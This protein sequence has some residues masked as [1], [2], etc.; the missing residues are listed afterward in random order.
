[1]QEW[2]IA[3]DRKATMASNGTFWKAVLENW[4]GER[5]AA[6]RGGWDNESTGAEK[7]VVETAAGQRVREKQTFVKLE[8]EMTRLASEKVTTAH[9]GRGEGADRTAAW[10][11]TTCRVEFNENGRSLGIIN[12]TERNN[13]RGSSE[14]KG[15]AHWSLW[16]APLC[17]T[18]KGTYCSRDD[19]EGK[20][21][22]DNRE[23]F[24]MEQPNSLGMVVFEPSEKR[25]L[26]LVEVEDCTNL[27]Q[28]ASVQGLSLA[29]CAAVVALCSMWHSM[30]AAE[31]HSRA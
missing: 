28:W 30:L 17:N 25:R 5:S 7:E 26:R 24:A 4:R 23:E 10:S 9:S 27:R 14:S 12:W 31:E 15:P 11:N 20:N 3:D 18:S 6:M 21:E 22:T 13:M 19:E 2:K 29:H 16:K 8:L 1:M